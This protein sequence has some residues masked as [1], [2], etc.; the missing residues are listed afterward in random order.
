MYSTFPKV[1]EDG[2][3]VCLL[4]TELIFQSVNEGSV[5]KLPQNK[6]QQQK[7]TTAL[8]HSHCMKTASNGQEL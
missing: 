7:L 2:D 4:T 3:Y 6:Q 8:P 5:S 1:T